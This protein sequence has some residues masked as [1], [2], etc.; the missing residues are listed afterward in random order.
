MEPL[1]PPV[2][3]SSIPPLPGIYMFKDEGGK[4][5]YVGKAKDLRKRVG[6]Y[7]SRTISCSKTLLLIRRVKHIDFICTSNEKEALLLEF[8]LIK[9]YRP[10]F[11]I[12]LRD[13]KAYLLFKLD[14][15][16]E[17]P[18]LEIT[19]RYSSKKGC[20]YFG[21]YTSAKAARSTFRLINKLFP[22]RKCRNSLFKNRTRPCLQYH[23]GRC[24]A[25]CCRPVDKEEYDKV[26]RQV[27]MFLD[28][29]SK[30]LIRQLEQQMWEAAEKE[31]FE[32]A[33]LLRDRLMEIKKTLETQN[34]ILPDQGDVDVIGI[35]LQE[36]RV[37]VGVLFVRNG[38]AQETRT[39]EFDPT[40]L[41]F[42]T[43]NVEGEVLSSFLLQFYSMHPSPA[44]TILV[45]H[46]LEGDCIAE[47]LQERAGKKIH[48]HIPTHRWEKGLVNLVM[49]N[50][51]KESAEQFLPQLCALGRIL[52]LCSP[53]ARI[54]II[55][56]SHI[57]GESP[58][59]GQVVFEGNALR[60]EDYRI[61]KFPELTGSRDD[62]GLLY[63]WAIRRYKSG[64]PWPDV[65]LID[66]GKGQIQAV[67]KGFVECFKTRPPFRLI[68]IAK[69]EGPRS[70]AL[71]RVYVEGRKNP[72]PLKKKDALLLFL[73]YLRDNAHNFVKS[74]LDL[75]FKGKRGSI[76]E[77]VPG[78]GKKT[79]S[80]LWTHFDSL[81]EILEADVETLIQVPG[82][83]PK[84]AK[85]IYSGLQKIREQVKNSRRHTIN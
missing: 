30:Q 85:L 20:R 50:I 47:L 27:E 49:I 16:T 32:H 44:P 23:L 2:E 77:E 84:R 39:Y 81:S 74:R 3:I 19:R 42:S 72:L 24:L 35:K 60:K 22:L 67:R 43:E 80:L 66:G 11:N 82:I 76:L 36:D 9:K 61:Y 38:R 5:L 37:L 48:I 7:F 55:D 15:R 46:P 62:Y 18:R 54:E 40:I 78:I 79:A 69:G 57:A 25:P 45:S 6:S 73:Q 1:S 8:S 13:D 63:Q 70:R 31:E 34:V 14:K 21:P 12:V 41:S 29:R 17:F 58:L 52:G 4:V 33:A 75:S 68:S 53:P 56:A 65:V 28:G 59:V 64:P 83:G 71:D 10:P 26:V 51:L